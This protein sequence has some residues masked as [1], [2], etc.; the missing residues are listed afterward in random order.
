MSLEQL[1]EQLAARH[2]IPKTD[3][4]HPRLKDDP[5]QKQKDDDPNY[6]PYC[7]GADCGR[8]RRTIYGFKCP[9]CGNQMNYD[10]T[11][12]DGN[13][14]VQYAGEAPPPEHALAGFPPV[15]GEYWRFREPIDWAAVM[16]TRAQ[17]AEHRAWNDAVDAKKLAKKGRK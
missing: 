10:L 12:Y 7:F 15:P 4:N 1:A 17:H 14:H 8:T 3:I 16:Q 2:R 6:V 9:T 13:K 5:M 11:H